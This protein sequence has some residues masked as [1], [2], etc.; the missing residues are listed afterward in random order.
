MM[1]LENKST[2]IPKLIDG[3]DT[4]EKVTYAD[5]IKI[6]INVMP[7][8]GLSFNDNKLRDRILA[9]VETEMD[10]VIKFEDADGNNL[11][12]I[13]EQVKLPIRHKDLS[14]FNDDVMSMKS[15]IINK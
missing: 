14:T 15:E 3:Q 6:V 1:K 11:K 10:G 7:Q 12:K 4:N 13:C 8:G 9:S 5:L 2:T